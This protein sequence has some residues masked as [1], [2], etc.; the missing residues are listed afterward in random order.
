MNVK[1][2]GCYTYEKTRYITDHLV[3]T[4]SPKQIAE[5]TSVENPYLFVSLKTICRWIY[6]Q[7]LVKGNPAFLRHK[8]KHIQPYET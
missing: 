4:S 6:Q 7:R 8:G 5:Q 2:Q 3:E 1:I